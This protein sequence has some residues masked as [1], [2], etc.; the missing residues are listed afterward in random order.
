MS[1]TT[2]DLKL[3]ADLTRTDGRFNAAGNDSREWFSRASNA[4]TW[5]RLSANPDGPGAGPSLTFPSGPNP[6]PDKLQI[7]VYFNQSVPWDA[8]LQVAIYAIFTPRAHHTI[9]VASP[10]RTA[11]GN[12]QV[13]LGGTDL[14]HHPDVDGFHAAVMPSVPLSID[15]RLI[16]GQAQ[17]WRFE[18]TVVAQFTFSSGRVLQYAYDPEMDVTV[19]VPIGECEEK[20]R[21]HTA[22]G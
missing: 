10:F 13:L 8:T 2:F 20:S 18:F 19:D 1:H 14:I 6:D 9:P 7:T 21:P 3:T 16:P 12:V 17:T 15:P 22:A 5:R 11:N 4:Q